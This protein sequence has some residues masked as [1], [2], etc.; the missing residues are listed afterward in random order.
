MSSFPLSVA[1]GRN[2]QSFRRGVS[3]DPQQTL[4]VL[5]GEV[6]ASDISDTTTARRLIQSKREK[7]ALTD[8][9]TYMDDKIK[10]MEAI[11]I[12][13][14]DMIHDFYN[15][16][17]LDDNNELRMTPYE[18]KSMTKEFGKDI[19][20]ALDKVFMKLYPDGQ[21]DAVEE[22]AKEQGIAGTMAGLKRSA[23][24]KKL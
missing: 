12:F 18:A 23:R 10:L 16:V 22:I 8:P 24:I 11:D 6:I 9:Q 15:G 2:I 19:A 7:K 3:T 14:R 13:L 5:E 20:L 1:L 17:L 21:N 4:R